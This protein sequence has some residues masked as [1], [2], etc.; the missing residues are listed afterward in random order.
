VIVVFGN[1]SDA[2]L[3]HV[4]AAK[5]ATELNATSKIARMPI[6]PDKQ[7]SFPDRNRYYMLPSNAER[8]FSGFAA[9]RIS[10]TK[11]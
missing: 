5:G 11:S 4:A 6:V 1:A 2:K 10:E 8:F 7:I 3:S 9:R